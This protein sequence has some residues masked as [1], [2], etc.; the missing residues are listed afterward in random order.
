MPAVFSVRPLRELAAPRNAVILLPE[1]PRLRSLP[2][3]P[4]LDAAARRHLSLPK[5]WPARIRSSTVQAISL[6][7]FSAARISAKRNAGALHPISPKIPIESPTKE[8]EIFFEAARTR[9][10]LPTAA[11]STSRTS[12]IGRSR[13]PSVAPPMMAQIPRCLAGATPSWRCAPKP[14]SR[15]REPDRQGGIPSPPRGTP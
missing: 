12:A 2:R 6:A 3:M 1:R 11:F 15:P 14:P 5:G 10:G 4:M 9:S 7:H 8:S 13:W